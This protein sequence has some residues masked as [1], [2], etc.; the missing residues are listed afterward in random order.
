MWYFPAQIP[1]SGSTRISRKFSEQLR[2]VEVMAACV[3]ND[4]SLV[5]V[6]R[7]R[8]VFADT[9]LVEYALPDGDGER[10]RLDEGT[11]HCRLRVV[12][13]SPQVRVIPYGGNVLVLVCHLNGQIECV[14]FEAYPRALA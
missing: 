4:Y 3:F 10:D 1:E 13:K 8:N 6:Q 5:T 7:G 14:R 11:V 2:N 9:K 12:T